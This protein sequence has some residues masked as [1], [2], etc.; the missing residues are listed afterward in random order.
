M[1]KFF[2][3]ID[4]PGAW[5]GS[6]IQNNPTWIYHIDEDAIREIDEALGRLKDNKIAIPFSPDDFPLPSFKRKLK[7]ILKVLEM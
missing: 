7:H 4:E 5:I 3:I 1:N 6:E 2:D